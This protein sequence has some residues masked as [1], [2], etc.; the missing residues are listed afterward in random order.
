LTTAHASLVAQ[1]I[2]KWSWFIAVTAPDVAI[3]KSVLN[4]PRVFV[5]EYSKEMFP[6]AGQIGQYKAVLSLRAGTVGAKFIVELDADDELM[7]TALE[8]VQDAFEGGA[9]FV[10]SDDAYWRDMP[11]GSVQATWSGYP[12]GEVYGWK[13]R[14]AVEHRGMKLIAQRQP[15]VTAQNIRLVD[16]SPDHLRAW[17]VSAYNAVGGHDSRMSVG[18]DHELIVKMFLNGAKFHHIEECLYIYRVHGDGTNTTALKNSN[19]RE[20]T[21]NT[22]AK[23]IFPL[24]EKFAD[25]SKLLKV[26]L[27]G[28]HNSPA[29][30]L[31]LDSDSSVS[32]I[33]G[34]CCDLEKT[35]PLQNDS[36]GL[37]RAIDAVEH[38]RDPVH[39][40]NEA[41]RVLAP[42]GFLLI[43]VPSTNGAGAWCDPTHVS[44]W[45][46]LS[47]RY[48]CDPDYMRYVPKFVG[49]FQQ[50]RLIEWFPN[51][52]CKENNIPYVEVVLAKLAPGY[53]PMGPMF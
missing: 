36:V 5:I 37:I 35:W 21:W 41:F 31:A 50:M 52:Y 27:C 48:Y 23:Y 7:P 14:Y 43:S 49:R 32:R 20:A 4:D 22:F 28:A 17:R 1:T 47:F 51:N 46:K 44:F 11:D 34:V 15:P 33:G 25:D 19:I 30:Y 39:T 3:P 29:G 6:T 10:Y 40:M 2:K 9:D 24:A 38:M 18:D 13:H 42:G 53:A 45:N 16:W 12:F 8:R 26:D